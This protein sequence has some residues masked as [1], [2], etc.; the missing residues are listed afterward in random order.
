MFKKKIASLMG[1]AA[2]ACCCAQSAHAQP[3]PAGPGDDTTPSMGV[4]RI[5][6]LPKFHAFLTANVPFPFWDPG[7]GKLESSVLYDPNTIIQRST[8]H[9]ALLPSTA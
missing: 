6:V 5:H 7:T 8:S 1:L 2:F 3:F 4:F 9:M